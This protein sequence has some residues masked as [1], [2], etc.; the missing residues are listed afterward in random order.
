MDGGI[1]RSHGRLVAA[2]ASFYFVGAG[3]HRGE[4]HGDG[5][6]GVPLRASARRSVMDAVCLPR[7]WDSSERKRNDQR[8]A[9]R[10]GATRACWQVGGTQ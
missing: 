10:H 9:P 2:F 7:R 8:R 1:R 3:R 6:V 5:S 4:R